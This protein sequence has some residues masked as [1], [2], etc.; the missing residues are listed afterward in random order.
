MNRWWDDARTSREALG[1]LNSTDVAVGVGAAFLGYHGL[2]TAVLK[3]LSE[4]TLLDQGQVA[5]ALQGIDLAPVEKAF[6]EATRPVMG[7]AADAYGR[8]LAQ[9][10]H[11]RGIEATTRFVQALANRGVDWP[12]AVSRAA[13]IHGVPLDRLGPSGA[14]L[15]EGR[16]SKAAQAD[17]G[18]RVLMEYASRFGRAEAGD[19]EVS[20]AVRRR[21]REFDPEDH[22]RDKEGKFRE[23]SLAGLGAEQKRYEEYKRYKEFKNQQQA[24]QQVPV[25]EKQKQPKRSLR[26]L[27][28]MMATPAA[29]AQGKARQKT[30]E[31]VERRDLNAGRLDQAMRD[32]REQARVKRLEQAKAD[33]AEA[34]KPR[35]GGDIDLAKPLRDKPEGGFPGVVQGLG[36]VRYALVPLAVLEL[37]ERSGEMSMGRV[38]R[39]VGHSVEAVPLEDMQRML[40]EWGPNAI[41]E[42]DGMGLIMI[43]GPAAWED[44]YDAH[45]PE[46]YLSDD[47]M[48]RVEALVQGG[49]AISRGKEHGL[50]RQNSS[51]GFT[52]KVKFDFPSLTVRL[53]NDDEFES[54]MD[55]YASRRPGFHDL[56]HDHDW[57]GG[58]ALRRKFR[59]EDVNRD[60]RGRFAEESQQVSQEEYARY[61]QY[62]QFKARQQAQ[63]AQTQ[64]VEQRS[65]RTSLRSRVTPQ[66]LAA[67]ATV[68]MALQRPEQT[69]D[70][71]AG[72]LDQVM[73]ERME[74]AR[75][76]VLE[77]RRQDQEIRRGSY[78]RELRGL[79]A[80][81]FAFDDAEAFSAIFGIDPYA[82][83]GGSDLDVEPNRN[84]DELLESYFGEGVASLSDVVDEMHL[85]AKESQAS[86]MRSASIGIRETHPY[87]DDALA[88]AAEDIARF[89]E[90]NSATHKTM[91][92]AIWDDTRKLF[93][94]TKVSVPLVEEDIL[95]V[96]NDLDW[97]ALI[98][99]DSW[100]IE[101][102]TVSSDGFTDTQRRFDEIFSGASGDDAHMDYY[103]RGGRSDFYVRAFRL[104]KLQNGHTEED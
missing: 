83:E 62:K 7:E 84:Y 23:K 58:K 88:G 9:D 15:Q 37:A 76:R 101:P 74:A 82:D 48:Y 85:E 95:V 87:L 100:V 102:L 46:G 97:T 2:S 59:E 29:P 10:V 24:R 98:S 36:D 75:A 70:L 61:Q 96:G 35:N 22:P 99:G 33:A 90:K 94:P 89:E 60:A 42:L 54:V 3:P 55:D 25:E 30:V 12:T 68:D 17:F 92:A 8:L 67:T 50:T 27:S 32:R 16:L 77:E 14:R 28:Q 47:G 65:E 34:V 19:G 13:S 57:Y 93:K 52:R 38:S 41:E 49:T 20:K 11:Q 66:V 64:Q 53:Q 81:R 104:R 69:R 51:G 40:D 80:A 45:A 44:G 1:R 86:E 18:D 31:E 73:R 26:Q 43:D 79:S 39:L 78:G 71:N 6:A 56:P 72:R 63:Q 103:D 21:T 4:Q 91:P 5:E